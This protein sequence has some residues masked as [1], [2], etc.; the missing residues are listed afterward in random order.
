MP[1]ETHV[2]R[3]RTRVRAERE[4]VAGKLDAFEAFID[5]IEELSPDPTQSSTAGVTATVGALS[6]GTSAPEDRCRAVRTAFAETI[7]PH[8]VAEP[9]D[10]ESLL[11]TIRSEF[12]DSIAVAL[13]PTTETSF[14]PTLKR[15]LVSEAATRRAETEVLRRALDR[16][17]AHLEEAGE[18]VD[19]ITAWI[20]DADQTPLTDIGF[21]ALR[22]R[23]ETLASHRDRCEELARARQSFLR[24]T[25][26]R[27]A[28]VGIRHR[29][30]GPYLYEDFPVDNPL[31]ATV[32]RLDE[33][34]AAC[35]RAVRQHLVQRA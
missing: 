27:N 16:E 21:E 9:D 29:N 12:S 22:D 17:G 25:T 6:R 34:C 15:A 11:T 2:D 20:A 14:S 1:V 32:A 23:H 31:L 13:A 19:D 24:Q 18:T 26:A 4:A 7:R 8:S 30:L 5:R 33:V 10:P 28:D 3:A 35:Q